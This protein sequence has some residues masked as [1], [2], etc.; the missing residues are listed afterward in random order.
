MS[1]TV[2]EM[3]LEERKF[4]HDLSNQLL[5]AQGMGTFANKAIKDNEAVES[6]DR[7]RLE[8]TLNAVNQMVKMLKERRVIL[9]SRSE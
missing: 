9:H 7:E 1:V 6:K 8:K 4:L 5:V 2:E 3:A